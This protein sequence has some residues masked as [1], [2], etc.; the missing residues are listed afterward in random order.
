[1][2]I[3]SRRRPAARLGP[4]FRPQ[5][6]SLEDRALLSAFY[7]LTPVASTAG[8]QFTSFGNLPS[9]NGSGTVA[10][11]G[12]NGTQSGLWVSS[13]ADGLINVNPTYTANG[14]GNRSFGRSVAIN[15]SGTLVATDRYTGDSA[16]Y[17]TRLW[18]S[19]TPDAHTDL[20]TVPDASGAYDGLQTFTAINADGD[21]AYVGLTAGGD[22]RD[23]NLAIA[24]S[25]PGSFPDTVDEV[26]VR[27]AGPGGATIPFAAPEPQ[28]TDDGRV[29]VYDPQDGVLS[30]RSSLG[31]ATA[32]AGPSQGFQWIGSA[33]GVSA[34]GRVVV[35]TGDRGKGP[36]VFASYVSGGSS[37]TI[38]RLA[39]EGLDSFTSFN[40]ADAVRINNTEATE[41]GATVAFMATSGL[42]QGIFTTRISFFGDAPNDFDPDDPNAVE[43]S[44][45]IPVALVGDP[46]HPAGSGSP[47]ATITQLGFYDGIDD[48]NRGELVFWAQESDGSQE[49]LKAEPRPV[50]WID[51]TPPVSVPGETGRN[52]S[53]L[54]QLNLTNAGW[55]G[56]FEESLEAIGLTTN[57]NTFETQIVAAVQALYT[58]A[59]SNAR[60]LGAPGDTPPP[61]IPYTV[62][63]PAGNVLRDANGDEITRGVYQ[64]VYV[65]GGPADAAYLGLA[66]PAYDSITG[67]LDFYNQ[68]PD[69]TAVVFANLLF[70]PIYTGGPIDTLSSEVQVR[71]VASVIAHE[72]GHNFGLYH[73]DS[74][75]GSL[76]M[77]AGTVPNEF[78]HPI[79]FNADPEPVETSGNAALDGVTESSD[80]RL[81]FTT[82]SPTL[83]GVPPDPKL[84]TVATTSARAKLG[85]QLT[86]G[87]VTVKDLVLAVIPPDGS[88]LFPVFQDLG[89]GDL[90]T[91][92]ANADPLANPDDQVIV[93][94]TTTGQSLDIVAAPDAATAG[95]FNLS[96]LG[97]ATDS[98]IRAALDDDSGTN[99]WQIFQLT[100]GGSAAPLGSFLAATTSLY[101]PLVAAPVPD[102]VVNEAT[103]SVHF[104]ITVTPAPSAT[105]TIEYTLAPGAP[106]GCAVGL[107]TGTFVFTPESNLPAG[108][109]PVTVNVST[110]FSPVPQSTSVTFR[111]IVENTINEPPQLDPIGNR[112]VAQGGAVAFTARATA[113]DAPSSALR[114]SLDPGAPEGAAIDPATGQFSWAVCNAAPGDY[115]VTV[116]VT[117][118]GTPSQSTTETID[119]HLVA[120]TTPAAGDPIAGFG[121]NGIVNASVDLP[122]YGANVQADVVLVQPDGKVVVG[123]TADNALVLLQY[124]ADGSLDTSFGDRGRFTFNLSTGATDPMAQSA[125][126]TAVLLANGQIEVVGTR[127]PNSQFGQFA[128]ARVNA[129]G[130]LDTSFGT[131]GV[132]VTQVG[133]S[134]FSDQATA[135]VLQS[136]G[137]LVVAG[138]LQGTQSDVSRTAV[139]RYLGD[140]ELDPSF[141]TGGELVFD[142]NDLDESE[143]T[144]VA[145]RPDG[146]IDVGG[147]AVVPAN[148][149]SA[150]A[151]TQLEPNGQ[152][153]P[154]FG[155]GGIVT[156]LASASGN[157]G[158]GIA[159]RADSTIVALD[160]GLDASGGYSPLAVAFNVDGSLVAGFGSHG[161]AAISATG[162]AGTL[163]LLPGGRMAV[164]FAPIGYAALAVLNADGSPDTSFGDG[165]TLQFEM[166]TSDAPGTFFNPSELGALGVQP[167]GKL[168]AAGYVA[169][170]KELIAV[171]R[172]NTD[173]SLDPAFAGDG[174]TATDLLTP[175]GIAQDDRTGDVSLSVQPDGK[176]LLVSQ[177]A[178]AGLRLYN[179]DGSLDTSFGDN[180]VLVPQVDPQSTIAG[181]LLQPDGDILLYGE[182]NSGSSDRSHPLVARVRPDGSL[183]PQF[184][185]DGAVQLPDLGDTSN[186]ASASSLVVQP[187]GKLV[188]GLAGRVIR[189]E[190]DGSLDTGFG[191]GGLVILPNVLDPAFPF[192]GATKVAL[193]SGGEI[194]ATSTS[195]VK[196][197]D[198]ILIS[199]LEPDGSLDPAFGSSGTV[200]TGELISTYQ[201]GYAEA[202]QADGKILLAAS[203]PTADGASSKDFS[204]VRLNADGSLDTTFGTAGV[205]STPFAGNALTGGLTLAGDGSILVAGAV[206]VDQGQPDEVALVRYTS[207]G[208]LD[209]G[210]GTGGFALTQVNPVALGAVGGFAGVGEEVM[211][212]ALSPD[213]RSA[214]MAIHSIFGQLILAG[215]VN[216]PPAAAPGALQ[217]QSASSSVD[218]TAGTAT[219]MVSRTGGTSGAVTVHY[220]TGDGT[221]STG[222]EYTSTSGTLTFADGQYCVSFT[223]PILNNH[224][225]EGDTTVALS[226]SNP[227][228]GATLGANSSAFLTIHADDG[229]TNG[230]GVFRFDGPSFV[231]SESDES[232]VIVV[233]RTGGSA[234][235]ATVAYTV[236]GGTAGAGVDFEPTSGTLTFGPGVSRQALPIPLIH[237]ATALGNTTAS[238]TLTNPTGGATL[239]S[240]TSAALTILDTDAPSQAVPLASPIN[241]DAS[242]G[243]VSVPV[244][245]S[246]GLGNKVAFQYTTADG[247]AVAGR[248]YTSISGT[249]AFPPGV[250]TEY[251]TIPINAGYTLTHPV[252]FALKLL[253]PAAAGVS[254]SSLSQAVVLQPA[255]ALPASVQP[256]PLVILSTS[257]AAGSTVGSLPGNEIVITFNHHLRGLTSGQT[258]IP[259]FDPNAL[260]LKSSAS[261]F[262]LFHSVYTANADGTSTIEVIPEVSTP[263]SPSAYVA[264]LTINLRDYSDTAG[265]I[266]TDPS[267]GTLTFTVTGQS[268]GGGGAGGG[269]TVQVNPILSIL[270]LLPETVGG[271]QPQATVPTPVAPQVT[272]VS[273]TMLKKG[274]TNMG[275]STVIISFSQPMGP[276]ATTANSYTL[277][278]A[279]KVKKHGEVTTTIVPVAF[280]LRS[281]SATRVALNL[282]KPS[283]KHLTL[284]VRGSVTAASGVSLGRDATFTL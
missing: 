100:G 13:A 97:V 113:L 106:A 150:L 131:Q 155:Q 170:A 273:T 240:R 27:G 54:K 209:S 176:L 22:Y 229:T 36:G 30:L 67:D 99:T 178:D 181:A 64:T 205:A 96:Q 51:F 83:E 126:A 208:T 82:G 153:D 263:L 163:A 63:D 45:A 95:A 212:I 260:S 102:L 190:P 220:Q 143:A 247:S 75:L 274:H 84:L 275:T 40:P 35:F 264:T 86:G 243:Y 28:L 254:G 272:S 121:S 47:G 103:G 93:L 167:D 147:Q 25:P 191:D 194:L 127:L 269:G 251:V 189:I 197:I 149:T 23:V 90:A 62:T 187:D 80:L 139:L 213:A 70:N 156:V 124:L 74:S 166:I 123:G 258:A 171:D 233:D 232:A 270:P 219:I 168:I 185:N 231:A 52:L 79:T 145:L 186:A 94:G 238:V 24:G 228:G 237:D 129:D 218:R 259:T 78:Q 278:I 199:R 134:D 119:I 216:A 109:Y 53:L 148:D 193:L 61:Y 226:L 201:T 48:D 98:S 276:T 182:D 105:S 111:L 107:S 257:P 175:Q 41:R 174:Q 196:Y 5:F 2:C 211:A 59:G 203:P 206:L 55:N 283:K 234:G 192:L 183:D 195:S 144:G 17:Y 66:S 9:V 15:D 10:F 224:R 271:R 32:I 58:D 50:I 140:G 160:A 114:F 116:R 262:V 252:S 172:F 33:P 152:L 118:A 225:N 20:A 56:D 239:A 7:D 141:A 108:V 277:G 137:K 57:Y 4:R 112:V 215:L 115:P 188:V 265:G 200:D 204:V 76:I 3:S 246:G 133:G 266:I 227:T 11:V 87:P 142:V 1:M 6:Q 169:I 261:S 26:P 101:P 19:T 18:S 72:A 16:Q 31:D 184:G 177:D 159:I 256:P 46:V 42:G 214:Y 122:T 68:I 91:L 241:A 198:E 77:A 81:A 92:L 255:P 37:R 223:I 135:A 249:V 161:I 151:L 110:D 284:V 222:D 230:P 245:R 132:V 165:G 104:P 39:G 281:N 136:D 69:D 138:Y 207:A 179:S 89:S 49:I 38:I 128:L 157:H 279:T 29:L 210:F 244:T 268:S 162:I 73:L 12:Y 130:T 250:A 221:A 60:V 146:R 202:V 8:G 235:T 236:T 21:A 71:T 217:F 44:G 34:D 242:A 120:P 248:D 88:D 164:G 117:E 173:G 154:S 125:M 65:G 85:V 43:V 180:G 282:V 253:Y 14:T 267:A 280:A 158:A